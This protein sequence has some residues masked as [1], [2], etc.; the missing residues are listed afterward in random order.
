LDI[1]GAARLELAAA[2]DQPFAL[3]AVRLVDV[4]P[5]G[6]ATRITHDVLN[7]RHRDDPANPSAVPVGEP[8]PLTLSFDDVGYRIPAG[9]RLRL[10][11]STAYWPLIWPSPALVTL[12]LDPATMRLVVPGIPA[13]VDRT[14]ADHLPPPQSAPEHPTRI[15]R[16]GAHK[17]MLE[18]DQATGAATI[19]ILDD[20]GREENL[21]TGIIVE[22]IARETQ[23]IQPDDPLCASMSAHWTQVRTR[24]DWHTRTE[25]HARMT[26]DRHAFTIEAQVDAY[27]GTEKIHTKTW[28]ETVP[29]DHV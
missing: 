4:H 26:A 7:V 18:V 27:E 16:E 13:G 15:I 6:A 29:R 20:F 3:L 1:L 11:L 22:E 23:V 12:S 5:D 14:I 2:F 17:R 25:A 10:S 28:R 21:E 19:H 24:G 9:H 8:L